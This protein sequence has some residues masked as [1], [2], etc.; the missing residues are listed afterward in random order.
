[1]D[2]KRTG[3]VF[4]ALLWLLLRSHG[5]QTKHS[6]VRRKL[7]SLLSQEESNRLLT[8]V[9]GG[10]ANDPDSWPLPIRF[11]RVLWHPFWLRIELVLVRRWRRRSYTLCLG[12][13]RREVVGR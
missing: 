2:E 8:C 5:S 13:R 3:A 12:L 4:I 7:F 1:M 10:V 9:V 11:C 6:L